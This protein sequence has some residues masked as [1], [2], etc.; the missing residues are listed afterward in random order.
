MYKTIQCRPEDLVDNLSGYNLQDENGEDNLL[1]NEHGQQIP[2]Y[3]ATYLGQPRCCGLLQNLSDLDALFDDDDL[4]SADEVDDMLDIEDDNGHINDEDEAGI[5]R[6][7]PP[8]R[9]IY[10]A[11]R[12]DAYPHAFLSDYGQW[13]AHGVISQLAKLIHPIVTNTRLRVGVGATVEPISSQ[14]YNTFAHRTRD[15]ARMHIAQRGLLTATVAGAWATSPKGNTTFRRL[16]VQS[17][18][19]LPHLRLESQIDNVR[20]TYLRFENVFQINCDRMKPEALTGQGFYEKVIQ[21]I[22][23]A[24]WHPDVVDALRT[25]CLVLR[26]EVCALL[27]LLSI[28]TNKF[29]SFRLFLTYTSG[30]H[31]L[32]QHSSN[33]FGRSTHS[34]ASRE[35]TMRCPQSTLVLCSTLQSSVSPRLLTITFSR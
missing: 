33:H 32:L 14:C 20:E 30:R 11:V 4:E 7:P 15:S 2:R 28:H 18:S 5:P 10:P 13:Q 31:T 26:P 27:C 8:R 35:G 21:P 22:L 9:P 16:F 24:Y 12:Y 17:D 1:F 29:A 23:D 19:T 25:R 6:H 34:L 3:H